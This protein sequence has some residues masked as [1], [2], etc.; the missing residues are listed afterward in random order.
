M[1]KIFMAVIALMMTINASAQ[2]YIYYSSGTVVKIDSI[3][4]VAPKETPSIGVGVF[5]VSDTKKVKFSKGNLQYHPAN[6]EWRFAESQLDY[7]GS[8]NRNISFSYNGWI[9]LF[10]WSTNDTYFGVST[11]DDYKNDYLGDFIDW[12]VNQ[13]DSDSS[14]IFRTLTYGE[15]NYILNNRSKANQL[16]GIARVAGVNGLIIL[17][18]DWSCPSEI[19][20]RAGTGNIESMDAYAQYQTFTIQEW[21]IL[22]TTGAVFLPAT[23]FRYRQGTD[24]VQLNGRYWSATAYDNNSVLTLFFDSGEI[25]FIEQLRAFAGAVRLVTDL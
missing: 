11:S 20:F 8:A 16:R 12:G 6:D 9:D 25:G 4:L 15:W 19:I 10:G 18:D 23:G 22:E 17:P 5:S 3:S 13:I 1:K 7:I 2:F 21:L 14:N 24:E